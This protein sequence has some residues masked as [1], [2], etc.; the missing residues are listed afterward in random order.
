VCIGVPYGT[1]IWKPHDSSILNGTFQIKLCIEKLKY[2]KEKPIGCKFSFC[3]TDIIP[4]VNRTW[5]TTLGDQRKVKKAISQRGWGPL[6]YTLLDHP[7][8]SIITE[9]EQQFNPFDLTIR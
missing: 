1:H 4:I 2:L 6:T 7:V 9:E 8:F 5:A 3:T